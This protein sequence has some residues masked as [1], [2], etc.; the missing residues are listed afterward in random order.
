MV[1]LCLKSKSCY[2]NNG[3]SFWFVPHF[4]TCFT[5]SLLHAIEIQYFCLLV[6]LDCVLSIK[7][8]SLTLTF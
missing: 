2:C 8:K 3:L 6:Y 5:V 7:V 4:F 1:N